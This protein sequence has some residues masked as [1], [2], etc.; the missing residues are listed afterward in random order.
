MNKVELLESLYKKLTTIEGFQ[1]DIKKLT[2]KVRSYYK[3]IN[4]LTD[5][6]SEELIV[7]IN[8]RESF[9]YELEVVERLLEY[10]NED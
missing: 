5:A 3:Y 9:E 1:E 7:M 8:N 4:E 10:E 2:E 6:D